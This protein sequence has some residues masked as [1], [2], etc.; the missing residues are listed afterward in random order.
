MSFNEPY[1]APISNYSNTNKGMPVDAVEA[2]LDQFPQKRAE[3]K[4]NG[5]IIRSI[6]D[7]RELYL[8]EMSP[9]ERKVARAKAKREHKQALKNLAKQEQQDAKEIAKQLAIWKREQRI[10]EKASEQ[11]KKVKKNNY[12]STRK[13]AKHKAGRAIPQIQ[14]E[15]NIRRDELAN[16]LKAGQLIE[17]A[18]RSGGTGAGC[19]YRQQRFDLKK[20]AQTGL[21]IVRIASALD[22][23][24][25]FTLNQFEVYQSNVKLVG[26]FDD[27]SKQALQVALATG[28]MVAADQFTSSTRLVADSMMRLSKLFNLDIY[29]VYE[30]KT[31]L[32]WIIPSDIKKP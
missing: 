17:V 26:N 15:S 11:P 1:F 4:P 30:S 16:Q 9:R 29:T 13:R 5:G 28:Q 22:R 21:Q 19:L 14:I 3:N 32:G 31:I 6:A 18:E 2:W 8:R 23:Q 25:Y 24:S 7:T 10:K 12:P 20:L 27:K